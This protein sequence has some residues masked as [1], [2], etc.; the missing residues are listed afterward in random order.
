M[1]HV[2]SYC[3][4]ITSL[5]NVA[6]FQSS[7]M[8]HSTSVQ[9]VPHCSKVRVNFNFRGSRCLKDEG[10]HSLKNSRNHLPSGAASLLTRLE[11]SILPLCKP[12]C[13][14]EMSLHTSCSGRFSAM[15]ASS[16]LDSP[17]SCMFSFIFMI[18]S[19]FTLPAEINTDFSARRP[20]S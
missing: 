14:Q 10:T 20:K 15:L 6:G 16:M 3:T 2:G 12:Q 7:G 13:S 18:R 9:V 19:R 4:W 1:H 17:C 5:R 8:W 11:P